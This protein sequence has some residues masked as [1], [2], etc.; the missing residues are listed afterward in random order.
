M[1]GVT[2]TPSH[3]YEAA[4]EVIELAPNAE[5]TVYP[6]KEEPDVLATTINQPTRA[7]S[8]F[9]I[10]APSYS[11][12]LPVSPSPQPTAYSSVRPVR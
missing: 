7:L 4:I 12:S 1:G 10:E 9:R 11:A 8:S 3:S 2:V 5:S 6:W